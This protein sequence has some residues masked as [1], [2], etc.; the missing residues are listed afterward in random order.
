M[1]ARLLVKYLKARKNAWSNNTYRS[2][3]SRLK[4]LVKARVLNG[5]PEVLWRHLEKQDVGRYTRVTTWVRVIA[6]WNWCI[7]EGHVNDTRSNPYR[8]FRSEN[9]RFFKDAYDRKPASINR[10][11]ADVLIGQIDDAQSQALARQLL[12]S[13]MRFKESF[14][15]NAAD[16]TVQGKTGKRKVF[17]VETRVDAPCSYRTFLRRCQKVGF[18]GTHDLRKIAASHFVNC[19]ATEWD[20]LK[21]MGW[22][23]IDT[24]RSY[25]ATKT[26]KELHE[27][28]RKVNIK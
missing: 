21:L 23:D 10:Q 25:I 4:G 16:G 7:Q 24:A 8:K 12:H 11:E 27:W 9:A 18:R 28:V 22:K 14:T 17:G 3:R 5:E 6:F 13:G 19:G 15:L 1:N 26:D 2:E 20:L